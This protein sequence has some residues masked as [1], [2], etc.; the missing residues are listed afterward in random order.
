MQQ[1]IKEFTCLNIR[2][3]M[4]RQEQK[5]HKLLPN[6]SKTMQR[7][8]WKLKWSKLRTTWCS[9]RGSCFVLSWNSQVDRVRQPA[10]FL[11]LLF[12]PPPDTMCNSKCGYPNLGSNL[13]MSVTSEATV[14]ARI[15]E[16][17]KGHRACCFREWSCTEMIWVF[18]CITKL[19]LQRTTMYSPLH[20][21][22]IQRSRIKSSDP[23]KRGWIHTREQIIPHE[24][25]QS[26]LWP[27]CNTQADS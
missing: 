14:S 23:E 10:S 13:I 18:G 9:S 24:E 22:I 16:W 2:L 27:V 4:E 3:I 11:H 1:T 19:L 6:N 26:R 8:P 20:Y 21:S 12:V 7:C 25:C 17:T 5:T 15:M